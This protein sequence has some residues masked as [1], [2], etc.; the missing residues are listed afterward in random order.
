MGEFS[1]QQH[2]RVISDTALTLPDIQ[3]LTQV[4]LPIIGH[5]AF[6]LYMTLACYPHNDTRTFVHT[7]LL[8][9]AGLT[10][11][12]FLDARGRL[13]GI[14]L[15]KTFQQ[16]LT[17]KTQWVYEMLEPMSTRAFLSDDTLASL[18]AHYLGED[19]LNQLI[20][21]T[22]PEQP[23]IPGKNVTASFFDLIGADSFK[24]M[25]SPVTKPDRL[26]PV[27]K[28]IKAANKSINL[29]LMA[30]MLKSFNVSLRDLKTN[31]AA[32]LVEKELYGLD[33]VTL[34]RQIQQ[35]LTPNH[36][37]DMPRLRNNLK[38]QTLAN[39]RQPVSDPL[40]NTIAEQDVTASSEKQDQPQN[41]AQVFLEQ[42]KNTAPV[43]YL[44]ALRQAKGGFITDSE[45]KVL[46]D[47]AQLNRLPNE[48]I[49]VILYELTM[50]EGR[51]TISRNL[52]QTIV[53]DWSQAGIQNATGAI[54]YLQER[55]KKRAEAQNTNKTRY[56][57]Q[58][59]MKNETPPDWKNQKVEAATAEE[60][61][62]ASR[63]LAAL[64]A[65]R[66]QENH[67]S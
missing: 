15:M 65:K 26:T 33:D 40:Q 8:D 27:Q 7:E 31:E 50:V 24:Q 29:D 45:L 51:S 3:A 4:Y 22:L 64:R 12:S 35:S 16:D 2:Y 56:R 53:N 19:T 49:N 57:N 43:A 41:P 36:E 18:L 21:D 60:Q 34:V 20:A 11:H 58:Q 28:D 38:Q 46:Q 54:K 1:L 47:I 30:Q 37:I 66:K 62:A 17:M 55:K 42:V 63:Q 32:L 23:A 25:K 59:P 39:Q 61:A 13:E 48:V 5:E 52:M 9:Q 14:G 44:K 10:H 67:K 6:T